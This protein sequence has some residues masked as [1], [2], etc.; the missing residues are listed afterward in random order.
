MPPGWDVD[1][2]FKPA[3][4]ALKEA[5][6][7]VQSKVA[8]CVEERL[9]DRDEL[10]EVVQKENDREARDSILDK[11]EKLLPPKIA[12]LSFRENY[13]G[14]LVA[15]SEV[16]QWA[17]DNNKRELLQVNEKALKN[18]TNAIEEDPK[19]PGWEVHKNRTVVITPS[20]VK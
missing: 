12:G 14:E 18:F 2:F 1:S 11:A 13:V 3:I 8:R 17:I 20:K 4:E 16:V 15:P 7:I 5:E 9:D 6:S 10:L 19:I